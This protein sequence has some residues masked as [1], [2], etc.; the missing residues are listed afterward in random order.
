M[1]SR[2][3]SSGDAGQAFEVHQVGQHH[4]LAAQGQHGWDAEVEFDLFEF[5][6]VGQ[7]VILKPAGSL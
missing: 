6:L 3:P 7:A 1:S 4:V 5:L 2:K